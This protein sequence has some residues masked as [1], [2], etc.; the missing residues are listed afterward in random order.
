MTSLL[1]L[2]IILS[3]VCLFFIYL[4]K[5]AVGTRNSIGK[6]IVVSKQ[7]KS[8]ILYLIGLVLAYI[9]IYS[10]PDSFHLVVEYNVKGNSITQ[11]LVN[12]TLIHYTILSTFF[13]GGFIKSVIKA[14][15]GIMRNRNSNIRKV[16]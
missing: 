11:Q 9:L 8:A 12:M 1:W 16:E 14:S 7:L 13:A 10:V 3:S 5:L 2:P 6:R 4:F 15:V